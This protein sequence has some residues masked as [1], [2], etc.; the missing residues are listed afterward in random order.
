MGVRKYRFWGA[1]EGCA[2]SIVKAV[3]GLDHFYEK[4]F[5]ESQIICE[6]PY[7]GISLITYLRIVQGIRSFQAEDIG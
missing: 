3:G 2:H 4:P 5:S 6:S 1:S 7:L